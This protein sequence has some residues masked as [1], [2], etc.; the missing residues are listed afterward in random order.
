[1]SSCCK[2]NKL[3]W[4]AGEEFNIP[5]CFFCLVFFTTVGQRGSAMSFIKVDQ[6]CEEQEQLP[7]PVLKCSL[8]FIALFLLQCILSPP[9]LLVDAW[10]TQPFFQPGTHLSSVP[11]CSSQAS[12]GRQ[13]HKP[14]FGICPLIFKPFYHELGNPDY[15]LECL[16]LLHTHR[17]FHRSDLFSFPL[18]EAGRRKLL[19]SCWEVCYERDPFGAWLCSELSLLC[20]IQQRVESSGEAKIKENL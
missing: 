15:C 13:L 20:A 4:G 2:Q 3:I 11:C 12:V 19:I 14:C 9:E 5:Q 18:K 7:V 16:C 6:W 8:N 1:M 10:C 17:D